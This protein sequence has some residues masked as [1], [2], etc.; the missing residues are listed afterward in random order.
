[1]EYK[2]EDFKTSQAEGL[3]WHYDQE[4][5]T[6]CL[7]FEVAG[8]GRADDDTP[9]PGGIK[10]SMENLPPGLPSEKAIA[11]LIQAMLK[12]GLPDA[13]VEG[14]DLTPITWK[15]YVEEYAA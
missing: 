9:C 14:K 4:T 2:T 13:Y 1:M 5:K 11:T 8:I 10:L 15:K 7:I 12:D 6:L 3:G